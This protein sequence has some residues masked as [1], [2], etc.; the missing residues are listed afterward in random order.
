MLDCL[1]C[2]AV[3]AMIGAILMGLLLSLLLAG[4]SEDD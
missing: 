3:G 2:G 1:V 4:R